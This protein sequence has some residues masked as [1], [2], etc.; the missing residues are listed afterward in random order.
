VIGGV[1]GVKR[2]KWGAILL[3]VTLLA[4]VPVQPAWA[5]GETDISGYAESTAA[6]SAENLTP[7]TTEATDSAEDITAAPE[8]TG[9]TGMEDVQDE[10][11]ESV[12]VEDALSEAVV[13]K[14]VMAG[15]TEIRAFV[16]RLYQLCL[17]RGADSEGL[18]YWTSSLLNKTKSGAQVAA[19][20]IFSQEYIAKKAS[21]AD[22]VEMLYRVMLG[23][24]SDAAGK[25]EWVNRLYNGQ[26]RQGI[27]SGFV[28]S[29][30]FA[31][32][33]ASYNITRGDYKSDDIRDKN[34]NVTA[35][36][37]R[38]YR[39]CLNRNPDEAG[40]KDWITRLLNGNMQ[41]GMVAWSF[42]NSKEFIARGIN[43]SDFVDI[44]YK[45][46]L[47]RSADAAGKKHWVDTLN[48]GMS[49]MW[50]TSGFVGSQEFQNLC[51]SYGIRAGSVTSTEA[52]DQ[53]RG[54]T[55]LVNRFYTE[56]LK[57][58]PGASELNYWTQ[59]L[60]DKSAS[61][62]DLAMGFF[63]SGEYQ[64]KKTSN[65]QFVTD[66]YASLLGRTPDT[67]GLNSWVSALN[68]GTSRQALCTQIVE[69][70]EFQKL[71][72][73]LGILRVAN[74]WADGT[75]YYKNGQKLSGWQTIDGAK[76]YFNPANSNAKQTG[77]GYVDGYKLYFGSNGVLVTDLESII[78]KQSS[79]VLKVNKQ[80]NVVTVYAK[81]GNNGYI[82]PVKSFICST[83]EATPLGVFSTP[84]KYRWHE[85]MGPCWG[86]WCTRINGGV[87]FHSVFYNSYNNNMNLSISAYNKLGTTASHGCVRL[88]AGDAKWIYDNCSLGT[89]VTVYNSSTPGPYGK[90]T[91]Y[92]LASWHSWDPTDPTAYYK[93]QQNGCH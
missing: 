19:D 58:T 51:I 88:K 39:T 25:Q 76:Y 82:I 81:D 69:S 6:E 13:Q 70:E 55:S 63:M 56:A 74:G 73:Q 18:N 52:R 44:L 35:F 67:A 21:D 31:S 75:Y 28:Y 48:S 71:C 27:F 34:P 50:V 80:A 10:P 64:N 32:I 68:S 9:T 90:P 93:C 40:L 62:L 38:L 11:E 86:Q 91:A 7:E 15:E 16:E 3:A 89:T 65:A 46:F 77:W 36:V 49:R 29:A 14:T 30:E 79:Y 53:N 4:G 23:R 59:R 2:V 87:L 24:N 8:V 78:G 92:K 85:L 42:L 43:N 41:G 22:Y 57:R 20:F 83:G 1:N 45:V 26:T 61:G 17:G 60:L 84:N 5:A 12:L 33:C 54:I 47:N 66:L 37:S 72:N